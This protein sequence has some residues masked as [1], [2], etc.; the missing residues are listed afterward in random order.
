MRGNPN[1]P[2]DKSIS[3]RAA[4]IA[5]L[6]EGQ[7]MIENF[8]AS[9]DCASTLACLSEL[10]VT[11]ER[12]D[13]RVLIHGV[14]KAGFRQS[15]G[16]L[17][18]GNSGTTMRLLT[19][20]LAGQNFDS[21]LTGDT[22]LLARPMARIAEPLSKMGAS[23]VTTHGNA[24]L[25][26]RGSSDLHS[27]EYRLPVASAQIKSAVLLAGLF[28]AGVTTVIE[29]V[30]TRDHT[31]RMLSWFGTEVIAEG[32]NSERHISLKGGQK[33]KASQLRIP[34]DVSAAAFFMVGAACL[35]GSDISI[36]NVG[37]NPTRTG[38][39]SVLQRLG[40][41]IQIV[42][43]T[44]QCNEPVA[45]LRIQGGIRALQ[46][47][48]PAIIEGSLVANLI[49]EIPILAVLGTQLPNGLEVRNASELRHKESD[50]ISSIVKGL[51]SMG[52][53]VK[54]FDDGFRVSAS[55]LKGA[56]VDSHDDHR[57][58][59]AFAIA[60]LLAEGETQ[61]QN[62]E[63]S[64]ISFPGFFQILDRVVM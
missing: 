57:I 9:A 17:D 14:G 46:S 34:T 19:G 18:C 58:A 42:D 44:D 29:P 33:I 24:P 28:A 38:F 7:T 31:E 53:D 61:I 16:P 63:C 22:S 15:A 23:I 20:I 54:E 60:G 55:R 36:R 41:S 1:L 39:I 40:V 4:L 8:S 13:D 2:A 3:H 25:R 12:S 49:D 47:N 21:T 59:M 48:G 51:G 56:E 62:A 26:I 27:I 10:G 11:I 35:P 45:T 43:Q 52:A 32:K 64:D 6:A 50:R 30:P 5:S 37:V